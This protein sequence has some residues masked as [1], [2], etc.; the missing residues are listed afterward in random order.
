MKRA[1]DRVALF[2]TKVQETATCWFWMGYKSTR[3][4]GRFWDGGR[5]VQAHRFA[6]ET[7]VGPIP[8]GLQL[9][10]LCRVRACVNPDHLEPV[11]NRE[12]ILRG[13]TLPAANASKTACLRGHTYTREST[14]I[15]ANGDRE[16][17]RCDLE[18]WHRRRLAP[19]RQAYGGPCQDDPTCWK[20]NGHDG[21]HESAEP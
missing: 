3:G 11:T 1:T 2:W 8:E 20:R 15:R 14:Y 17:R 4:Y 5:T 9:D 6:Y 7:R 21:E 16:C 13:K 10:H 12:N 19:E 18:R